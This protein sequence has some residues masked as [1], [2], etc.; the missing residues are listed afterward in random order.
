MLPFS[1]D[2]TLGSGEG[3]GEGLMKTT[4]LD[5]FDECMLRNGVGCSTCGRDS[6]GSVSVEGPSSVGV[7]GCCIRPSRREV[8]GLV[9]RQCCALSVCK[10]VDRWRCTGL[11]DECEGIL[12]GGH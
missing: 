11:D 7:N 3:G 1:Q 5:V 6:K 2:W 10:L 12:A 9:G 8:G 4:D